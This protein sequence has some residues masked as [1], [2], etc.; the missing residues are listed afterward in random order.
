MPVN[1]RHE[2]QPDCPS[3][4][5]CDFPLIFRSQACG[6][7][8]LYPAHLSHELGHH[9][10]VLHSISISLVITVQLVLYLVFSYGIDAQCVKDIA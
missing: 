5:L 3:Y 9:G 2:T 7:G 1:T 4:R 10:E 8:M 6:F